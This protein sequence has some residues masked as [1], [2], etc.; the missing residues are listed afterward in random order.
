MIKIYDYM[1]GDVCMNENVKNL[2]CIEDIKAIGSVE[3]VINIIEEVIKPIKIK[4][5]TYEELFE[6]IVVLQSRWVDLLED[7]F[8]KSEESKYLFCLTEVDGAKRNKVIGLTDE[9]YEDQEQA[10]KWYRKVVKIIRPDIKTDERTKKAFNELQKLNTTIV[11]IF[12]EDKEEM[13]EN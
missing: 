6:Y 10:K 4:A 11:N 12:K 3:D 13:E 9:L 2:K 5:T 8:F 7:E 1:Q